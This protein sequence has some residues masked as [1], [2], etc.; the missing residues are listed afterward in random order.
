MSDKTIIKLQKYLNNLQGGV[1]VD[2]NKLQNNNNTEE[3]YKIIE[4]N[5]NKMNSFNSGPSSTQ[6]KK[7]KKSVNISGG[8]GN[9]NN[10]AISPDIIKET[11]ITSPKKTN[12]DIDLSDKSNA[13]KDQQKPTSN[14][15]PFGNDGLLKMQPVEVSQEKSEGKFEMNRVNEAQRTQNAGQQG[16]KGSNLEKVPLRPNES[17]SPY[18]KMCKEK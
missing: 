2:L 4:K 9:S 13:F 14:L 11:E 5:D 1:D 15:K 8:A 12:F 17:L 16:S 18:S 3:L 6:R 7:S 10:S